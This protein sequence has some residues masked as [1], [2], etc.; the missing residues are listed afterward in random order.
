MYSDSPSK[1]LLTNVFWE[2]FA[3]FFQFIDFFVGCQQLFFTFD[4]RFLAQILVF[5][6]DLFHLHLITGDLFLVPGDPG[7]G[8]P[9]FFE[10]G[11]QLI[12]L[13]DGRADP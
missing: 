6:F 1:F 8:G 4:D 13:T 2:S 7:V 11:F 10:Q 12:A 9:G 5:S 3:H